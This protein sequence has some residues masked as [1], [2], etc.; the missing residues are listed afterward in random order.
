M[1]RY[2]K[3]VL[4][5]IIIS[6]SLTACGYRQ[7]DKDPYEGMIEVNVGASMQW[8]PLVENVAVSTLVAEDFSVC[9]DGYV[10]Y[11]GDALHGIDVSE[12]Q[13]EIDWAAVAESGLVDFAI[14]RVGY[15][16]YTEGGLFAD[17]YLEEN[18][19]GASENGIPVGVYFFSQAVTQAEAIEEAE[20]VLELID[21]YELDYPIYFDWEPVEP[22]DARTYELDGTTMTDCAI[23]FC[24]TIEDSGYT[25]GVY[26]Y[27]HIA[28][29]DYE[30]DRI[31]DY[32]FWIGAPADVPDFY[33]A[34][35]TWQ[36]SF[37][38]VVDGIEGDVD[39]NLRFE[40]SD[41]K[42]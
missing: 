7:Q 35:N 2:F 22:T 17:E 12:H 31:A 41:M 16:G 39:M 6:L 25:A 4:L 40:F 3:T 1:S 36:Y 23:A 38:G 42:E 5:M 8:L 18:L 37:T 20:Y 11:A 33:Y 30:L 10:S 24:Q 9:D 21:G 34:Y 27:R 19:Q 28:Y 15:R 29:Y 26:F 13:L 14:I 32:E